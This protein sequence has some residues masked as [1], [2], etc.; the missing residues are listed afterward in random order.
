MFKAFLPYRGNITLNKESND[1]MIMDKLIIK[2]KS[3]VVKE[4][5]TCPIKWGLNVY[6]EDVMGTQIYIFLVSHWLTCVSPSSK[7][8]TSTSSSSTTTPW[9]AC[10]MYKNR[11]K[12]FL[13]SHCTP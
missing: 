11:K 13:W 9:Q 2:I 3:K 10:L 7:H 1:D 6:L 12:A 5:P 4:N 8:Y